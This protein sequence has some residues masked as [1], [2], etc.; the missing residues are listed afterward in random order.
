[1]GIK[2]TNHIL[3]HT[4]KLPLKGAKKKNLNDN[5]LIFQTQGKLLFI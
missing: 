3:K 1:M 4:L 5:L 2:N